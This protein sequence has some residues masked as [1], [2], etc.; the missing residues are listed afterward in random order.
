M[1]K[2]LGDQYPYMYCPFLAGDLTVFPTDLAR[3]AELRRRPTSFGNYFRS[4]LKAR[5]NLQ[6]MARSEP[7]QAG[8]MRFKMRTCL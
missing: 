7:R 3:A 2:S 8:I 5:V 6:S 4:A 1:Y